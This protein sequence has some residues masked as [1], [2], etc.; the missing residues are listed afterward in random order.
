VRTCSAPTVARSTVPFNPIRSLIAR[1]PPLFLADDARVDSQSSQAM[2]KME[3]KHSRVHDVGCW[4]HQ[5]VSSTSRFQPL[6]LETPSHAN[7][8][9]LCLCV[10]ERR[11]ADTPIGWVRTV[12]WVVGHDPPIP[13]TNPRNFLQSQ[14]YCC[15]SSSPREIG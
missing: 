14:T 3:A 11:R 15:R 9:T 12:C 2:L 7:H 8:V 1:L 5:P 6:Y 4:V 13:G 10:F